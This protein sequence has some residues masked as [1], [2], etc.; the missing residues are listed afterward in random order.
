MR[1][2]PCD[3]ARRTL[4]H[5]GTAARSRALTRSGELAPSTV[6]ASSMQ[7]TITR[8]AV[9]IDRRQPTLR[10]SAVFAGAVC[11]IGIWLLLQL[12]GVGIGLC[13]QQIGRAHV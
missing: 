11:S 13:A 4:A 8:E 12:V 9:L 2:R 5:R 7:P 10:W 6:V 1:R 3:G